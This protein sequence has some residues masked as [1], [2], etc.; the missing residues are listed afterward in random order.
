MKILLIK[1]VKTLGKAGEV[2]EV[3]DGYG[4]NF[5]IAK[6]FAKHA[7]AEILAQHK[8]DEKIAAE[9]L[10]KEIASLKDLAIKLDK[11]EIVITKKL[12]QNGQLFGS[13]TKDEVA[14]AL[15]EQHS[16]EID[17][18]HITDKLSIKSVGEHD[19]DLRLGHGIHATLHVDVVGE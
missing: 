18:K 19:L 15:L 3:K 6:G 9:N 7:T 4:Q 11:A 5:L 16:I 12:G 14:H 2:K 10:A 1:D 13:I 8:E 17:K